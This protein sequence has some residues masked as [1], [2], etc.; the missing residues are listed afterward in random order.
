[1]TVAAGLLE[2]DHLIDA[3]VLEA[4]EMRAHVVGRADAALAEGVL[5]G[6]RRD[7]PVGAVAA[8]GDEVR[9]QARA[10]RH[11]VPGDQRLDRVGEELEAFLAAPDRLGALA[12]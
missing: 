3:G 8:L 2:E 10:T 4:L 7:Q 5:L 12:M 6:R 9:P 11:R 1:M